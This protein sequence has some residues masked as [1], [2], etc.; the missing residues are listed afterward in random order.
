VAARGAP[1]GRPHRGVQTAGDERLARALPRAAADSLEQQR[2][3][4]SKL[5]T[6]AAAD[7]EAGGTGQMLG[8]GGCGGAWQMPGGGGCGG[9]WQM[10]GGGG[11]GGA[12]QM[13]GGGSENA[14]AAE[15]ASP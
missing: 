9:A 1:V 12:W 8:G 7:T 4:F 15:G 11:C 3:R 5:Q 13:P 2:Q 10:P 6:A 14:D